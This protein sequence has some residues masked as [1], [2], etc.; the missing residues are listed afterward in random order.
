M[1]AC[2]DFIRNLALRC[3]IAGDPSTIPLINHRPS[4]AK[5]FRCLL[6][7][8]RPPRLP[9]KPAC[10]AVGW[11]WAC[12]P[13]ASWP[14][15]FCLPTGIGTRLRFKNCKRLWRKNSPAAGPAWR[16]ANTNRTNTRPRI[17]RV[18]LKVDFPP[19]QE[20]A[21]SEAHGR[22]R[23]WNWRRCIFPIRSADYDVAEIH[24]YWPEKE[25]TIHEHLIQRNLK[26]PAN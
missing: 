24:L 6:I 12:S 23:A 19:D 3:Q 10:R 13:S 1:P 2:T 8:S 7:L 20:T 18:V 21:K 25:K 5:T 26:S 15:G 22:P 9:N 16:A 11:C 4:L 14:R 17:L